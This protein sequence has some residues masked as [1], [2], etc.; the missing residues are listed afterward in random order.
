M[1]L[2]SVQISGQSLTSQS[3]GVAWEPPVEAR[4]KACLNWFS[5]SEVRLRL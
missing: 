5:W 1:P 3:D 2:S 4:A